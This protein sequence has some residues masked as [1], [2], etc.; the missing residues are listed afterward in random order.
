MDYT[1]ENADDGNGKDKTPGKK[2]VILLVA[3]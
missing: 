3:V 2:V 1:R